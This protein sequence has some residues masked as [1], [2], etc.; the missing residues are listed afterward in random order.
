V[1]VQRS[2]CS[3]GHAKF[4]SEASALKAAFGNA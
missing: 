1:D 3:A 2:S 4:A